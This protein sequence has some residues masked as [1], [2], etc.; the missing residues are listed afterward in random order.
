MI[1][2]V[3]DEASI[4]KLMLQTLEELDEVFE[5]LSFQVATNGSEAVEMAR[6]T[7]PDVVLLDVMMPGINGYEVCEILRGDETLKSTRVIMV[8]ARGQDFDR[9]HG[10]MVGADHYVTK[11]FDPGVIREMVAGILRE[12]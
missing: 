6:K 1:L 7:P 4:R 2:I 12:R 11:P 10:E 9:A 3:D 8:T 5:G